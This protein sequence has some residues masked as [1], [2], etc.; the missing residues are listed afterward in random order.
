MDEYD[1]Y[2][3]NFTIPV[4]ECVENVFDKLDHDL[5][6]CQVSRHSR[7]LWD[8][9]DAD[10]LA[11]GRRWEKHWTPFNGEKFRYGHDK[12]EGEVLST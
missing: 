3:K 7:M 1:Q 5:R 4:K 8:E 9:E 11:P 6:P 10:I 2:Q 12:V